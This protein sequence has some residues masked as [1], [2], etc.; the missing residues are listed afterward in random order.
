MITEILIQN[1]GGGKAKNIMN[2]IQEGK[3]PKEINTN[4]TNVNKNKDK[5]EDEIKNE[6]TN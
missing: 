4:K 6:N 2:N 1:Y 5:A 3:S